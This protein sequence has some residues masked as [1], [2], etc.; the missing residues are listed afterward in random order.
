[1]EREQLNNILG[2]NKLLES[3]LRQRENLR[4]LKGAIS[5][6]GDMKE[7]VQSSGIQNNVEK[8]V[9]KIVDLEYKI[10]DEI[11]ELTSLQIE[12]KEMFKCLDTL[13][14]TIMEMK[15]LECLDWKEL[16]YRLGYSEAH[17]RKIHRE[18]LDV[19]YGN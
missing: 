6:P 10:S 7:R 16:S 13:P 11:N 3:N 19:M 2:V 5:S 14:R 1:M 15:Y 4:R 8:Y 17:A 12:A 18:A 9:T